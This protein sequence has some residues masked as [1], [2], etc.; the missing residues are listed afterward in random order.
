M[1][2]SRSRGP[3]LREKALGCDLREQFVAG[4]M[5]EA[6]DDGAETVEIEMQQRR[7]AAALADFRER[8]VDAA[9]QRKTVWQSGVGVMMGEKIE[10]RLRALEFADVGIQRHIT[11]RRPVIV[12]ERR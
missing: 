9:A 4:G 5:S 12:A 10:P 6:F 11:R 7:A 2:A 3:S 8:G 1:R